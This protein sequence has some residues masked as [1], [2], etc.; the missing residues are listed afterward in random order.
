MANNILTAV[1]APV[2]VGDRITIEGLR[3]ED[4]RYAIAVQQIAELFQFLPSEVQIK[5]ERLLGMKSS[6]YTFK[7]KTN[8]E[9]VKGVRSRSSELACDLTILRKIIRKLDKKGNSVAEFLGD[10]LTEVA[11]EQFW[12]D[13]FKDELTASDRK[14]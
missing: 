13:A 2:K 9:R 4:G 7:V 11:I 14:R 12:A 1:V 5:L 10:I 3:L 6:L 8:R